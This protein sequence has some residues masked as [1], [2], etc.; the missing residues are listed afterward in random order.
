MKQ[1]K[2][3]A[4]LFTIAFAVA[5]LG[6][7]QLHTQPALASDPPEP[8]DACELLCTGDPDCSCSDHTISG[9]ACEILC[10]HQW[11]M[12]K[13]CVYWPCFPGQDPCQPNK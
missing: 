8:A 5:I 13:C 3:E 2:K 6:L 7:F 1:F 12:T 11:I 10:D 4:I 9:L